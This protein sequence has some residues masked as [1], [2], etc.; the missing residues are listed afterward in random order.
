M[1]ITRLI[2]LPVAALLS[3]AAPL[4]ADPPE[5]TGTPS[6]AAPAAVEGAA[7]FQQ[8]CQNCHSTEPGQASAIGPNLAAVLG[9][10]A[11]STE[12]RYSPALKASG[13]T[14]TRETLDSYLAAPMKLV[15]GTRMAVGLPDAAQR[16]AVIDYL[17]GAAAAPAPAPTG[18]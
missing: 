14:W 9:R 12:F 16:A 11:A 10:P 18:Q 2:L 1:S 6:P 4:P 17:A 8:R 15:P 5:P 13:I 7:L 3:A